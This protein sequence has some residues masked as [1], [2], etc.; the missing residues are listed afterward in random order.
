M[1]LYIVS[2]F[3]TSYIT[4]YILYMSI[5]YYISTCVARIR[6]YAV[7]AIAMLTTLYNMLTTHY[8]TIY[9][10]TSMNMEYI[11]Y[12]DLLVLACLLYIDMSILDAKILSIYSCSSFI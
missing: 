9:S 3:I 1:A 6:I 8:S 10:V 5:D 12:I 2:F 4:S 11:T 7:N